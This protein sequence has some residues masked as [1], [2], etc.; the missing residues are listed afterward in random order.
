MH[1]PVTPVQLRE[2]HPDICVTRGAYNTMLVC[3]QQL[4]SKQSFGA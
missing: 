1:V 3:T 4:L 2:H